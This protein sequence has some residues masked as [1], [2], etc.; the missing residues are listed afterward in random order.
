LVKNMKLYIPPSFRIISANI[1]KS[2]NPL[3]LK[4]TDC[5]AW[6]EGLQIPTKG[7]TTLYTGCEYQMTAY[8]GSLVEVLE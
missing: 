6:A 8:I 5:A 7:E 2:G 4:K 1:V 3:G